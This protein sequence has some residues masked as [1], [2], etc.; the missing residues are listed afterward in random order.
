M[1]VYEIGHLDEAFEA[2]VV[3][4]VEAGEGDAAVPWEAG[5]LE[6][7][8]DLVAV[9]VDGDDLVRGLGQQLLA[10]VGADEA[11]GADHADRHRRYRVPVQIYTCRH[12][13]RRP[14]HSLSLSLCATMG[15]ELGEW[16][17]CVCVWV[18]GWVCMYNVGEEKRRWGIDGDG[19]VGFGQCGRGSGLIPFLFA[20]F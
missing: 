10:E 9:D 11:A 18:R 13:R 14:A 3:L 15:A 12:R 4:D 5:G 20:M 1:R 8:L 6:Q 16:G 17:G 19:R 7:V 2:G